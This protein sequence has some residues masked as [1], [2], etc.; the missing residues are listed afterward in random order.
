MLRQSAAAS[1]SALLLMAACAPR[2][3]DAVKDP[4]A[5]LD[6]QI[7]AWRAA[8]EASHPACSIKVEGRGCE[9]FEITC[10]AAQEITPDERAQGVDAQVVAAMTFNGRNTDG[11]SG[12]PGSAFAVFSKADKAW[13]RTETRPVNMTSCAPV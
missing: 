2:A 13:T 3:E 8:L 7:L 6:T 10:K 1:L 11:S 12:K 5:G 4:Y 9:S